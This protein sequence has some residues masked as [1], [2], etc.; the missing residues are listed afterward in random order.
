MVWNDL[1]FLHWEIDAAQL[2]ALLPPGVELD[3]HAGRAWISLVPFTMPIIAPPWFRVPIRGLTCFAECNLRT[4]V[5]VNDVPGVWFFSLDAA[6]RPA[7]ELARRFWHLNYLVARFDIERGHESWRYRMTRTDAR[8][9]RD[10]APPPMLACAWSRGRRLPP[11]EPDSLEHF[12]T[13]RYALYTV[14]SGT[15]LRGRVAHVQWPL[16]EA[17]VDSI[18]ETLIAAAGLERGS[19]APLAMAAAPI[20]VE[21]WG[22]ERAWTTGGKGGR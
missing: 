16:H 14:R 3:T 19:E 22:L 20:D 1:L 11:T 2:Q 18:D 10:G 7:V 13:E 8:G 9:C 17:N 12:L 5:R 15:V 4:Y 21:G 6:S